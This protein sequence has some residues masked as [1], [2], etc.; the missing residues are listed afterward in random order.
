MQE[1]QNEEKR[2]E[3][4][5][6]QIPP[7]FSENLVEYMIDEGFFRIPAGKTHHG[8]F[9]GGNYFHSRMVANLLREYTEKIGLKWERPESPE[10]VGWLHDLCKIDEYIKIKDEQEKYHYEYNKRTVLC[11]HGDKSVIVALSKMYLTDEEI[12]CIFWHRGAFEGKEKWDN[13]CEAVK[14]YPNILWTHQADMAASQV[15]KI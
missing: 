9:E 11:G 1:K 5:L 14:R 3:E 13:Y 4:F 6:E 12:M 8:S 2:I 15:K 7:V 10:V